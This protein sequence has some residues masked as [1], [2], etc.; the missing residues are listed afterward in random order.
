L[1]GELRS[2]EIEVQRIGQELEKCKE[3][4]Q[5]WRD[6]VEVLEAQKVEMRNEMDTLHKGI[7]K[8]G[9]RKKGGLVHKQKLLDLEMEKKKVEG[10]AKDVE[11]ELKQMTRKRSNLAKRLKEFE[12]KADASEE[13]LIELL[14][15]QSKVFKA[16][17]MKRP[18]ALS[19]VENR[20]KVIIYLVLYLIQD[21][22]IEFV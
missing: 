6:S 7:E 22:M 11:K 3:E 1:E 18:E 10:F 17:L 16:L 20:I 2:K 9:A 14:K 21:E 13:K 15:M 8:L 5:M 19:S 4:T 12:S